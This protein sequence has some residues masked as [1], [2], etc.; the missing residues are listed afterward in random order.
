MTPEAQRI[1]IAEACGWRRHPDG[2]NWAKPDAGFYPLPK[3]IPDYLNDLNA[4]HDAEIHAIYSRGLGMV[5]LEKLTNIVN[6][7]PRFEYENVSMMRWHAS[8]TAAQRAETLL[9]TIGKLTD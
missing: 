3:W 2:I 1:A 6:A 5:Y 8:A 4:M 9:R 7:A